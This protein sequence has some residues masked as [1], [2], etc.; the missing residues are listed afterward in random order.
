MLCMSLL[1]VSM[2][3]T[4]FIAL[5][6]IFASLIQFCHKYNLQF[7]H[8]YNLSINAPGFLC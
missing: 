5:T 2:L 3:D 8:K 1:N 7:C 6:V 4:H